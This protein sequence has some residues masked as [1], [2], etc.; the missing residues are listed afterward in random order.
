MVGGEDRC[1]RSEG[2]G[3]RLMLRC[4]FCGEVRR[5]L[6]NLLDHQDSCREPAPA[7][8]PE[9]ESL[10]AYIARLG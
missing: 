4:E 6:L 7:P 10:R 2:E 5:G 3:R 8:L 1:C 9:P